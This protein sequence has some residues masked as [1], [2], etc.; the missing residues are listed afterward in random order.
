MATLTKKTEEITLY[1]FASLRSPQYREKGDEEMDIDFIFCDIITSDGEQKVIGKSLLEINNSMNVN[2]TDELKTITHIGDIIEV[3]KKLNEYKYKEID[4][5][6]I[7]HTLLKVD[8]DSKLEIEIKQIVWK[9][10]IKLTKEGGELKFKETLINIL[11]FFHLKKHKK[12]I[13]HDKWDENIPNC[14][15]LM[16]SQVVIPKDLFP[17]EETFFYGERI[18]ENEIK[19]FASEILKVDKDR[20]SVV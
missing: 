11:R 3:C 15:R 4:F 18:K 20:K 6:K 10:I 1:N 7:H 8:V 17:K 9:A 13:S 12:L 2:N 14:K 19:V 5:F 16:A